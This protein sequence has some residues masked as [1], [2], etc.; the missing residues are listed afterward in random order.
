[1]TRRLCIT[2]RFV[3]LHRHF[4]RNVRHGSAAHDYWAISEGR[5][6][7]LAYRRLKPWDHAAG[8]LIHAE[9]GGINKLLNGAPY[10]PG[11]PDQEGLLSAPD[12]ELWNKVAA[13]IEG[14]AA[15]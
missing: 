3:K 12:A 9:A 10:R 8:T 5:I 13:M 6:Q 14:D 7:L 2:G 4:A 1:M 11:M 15:R